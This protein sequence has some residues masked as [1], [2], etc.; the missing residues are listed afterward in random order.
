MAYW[1]YKM[2]LVKY[3]FSNIH[4]LYMYTHL[5]HPLKYDGISNKNKL[6]KNRALHN[7]TKQTCIFA[8]KYLQPK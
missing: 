5:H 3:A 6:I 8:H 7:D 4:T 2:Y 1:Y